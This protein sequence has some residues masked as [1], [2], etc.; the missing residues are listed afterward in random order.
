MYKSSQTAVFS[1]L[2][3]LLPS[4]GNAVQ[5]CQPNIAATT[6]TSQFVDNGDGT[7]TD[8]NTDL[9][10]KRCS[11][12]QVWSGSACTGTV[13]SYTWQAALL[14]GNTEFAGKSDWRLP[15]IKELS[16]I[17][18]EQCSSP[19]INATLFPGTSP[20]KYW[21]SSP[22]SVSTKQTWYVDFG[23]GNSSSILRTEKNAVRLVRNAL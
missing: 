2:L 13:G 1:C 3:A 15:N 11:D 20:S 23:R 10:W 18:E 12:G 14:Q 9:M 19:A 5:T 16:S 7:V 8:Q 22:D 4:L 17:V 21:T 6:S